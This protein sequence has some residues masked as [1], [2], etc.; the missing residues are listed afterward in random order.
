[1]L[2]PTHHIVSVSTAAYHFLIN[3]LKQKRTDRIILGGS[4]AGNNF[5]IYRREGI[6]DL[7]HGTYY[8]KEIKEKERVWGKV[9]ST[10]SR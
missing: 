10:Q 9:H 4:L 6:L 5:M 3:L 8:L 2:I 1:M 7:P